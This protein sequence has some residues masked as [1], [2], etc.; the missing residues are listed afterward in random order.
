MSAGE[1]IG[2][3]KTTEVQRHK[4][5]YE[6]AAWFREYECP[7]QTSDVYLIRSPEGFPSQIYWGLVGTCVDACLMSLF[8]G[9]PIGTEDKAGKAAV[10]KTGKVSVGCYVYSLPDNLQLDQG[11]E[12]LRYRDAWNREVADRR[13]KRAI[14]HRETWAGLERDFNPSFIREHATPELIVEFEAELTR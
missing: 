7:P 13:L 4:Q 10:G 6:T 3:I 12:W 11:Y 2:T 8:G 9:N 5:Q 14:Q 1:K